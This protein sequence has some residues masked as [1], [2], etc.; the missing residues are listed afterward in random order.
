MEKK[1]PADG[2]DRDQEGKNGETTGKVVNPEDGAQEERVFEIGDQIDPKRI[3]QFEK[4]RMVRQRVAGRRIR[5]LSSKR[6]SYVKSRTPHDNPTDVALD[7]TIRAAAQHM[8]SRPGDGFAVKVQKQDVREKVRIG[9]ISTPTVFV[10]DASG[11]MFTNE[12]M[13]SAKGAVLSMLED[14]Y[15]KRDKVGLVAFREHRGDVIL[16][17]CT[18]LD[19][20]RECLRDLATGGPTPLSAGLEKGLQLLMLE[21]RKNPEAM[22]LLVLISDGRANVP[23]AANSSIENELTELTD[24]AWKN[25]FHMIFI[26]VE[27]EGTAS[28]RHGENKRI[29]QD[30]M[31]YYH[32]EHLSSVTIQGI[33]STEKL[34]L[35]SSLG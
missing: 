6:G 28:Q 9:K 26:D 20:A 8:S 24:L 4:D 10:V 14:A 21:K 33:V 11:S 34:T 13:E 18:S 7:A 3:K 32:V 12:R 35:T 27:L 16:P 23:M 5:T 31:S 1:K 22:P 29:L 2:R 30:R 15:Q 19:Y 17:M 25:K